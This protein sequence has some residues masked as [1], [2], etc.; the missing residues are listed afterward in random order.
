MKHQGN[1]LTAIQHLFR[2]HFYEVSIGNLDASTV[3]RLQFLLIH[4]WSQAPK[5]S[6]DTQKRCATAG[7]QK[8]KKAT[9]SGPREAA[10]SQQVPRMLV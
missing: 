4:A 3:E 6:P 5:L 2:A 8:T 9:A 10:A 1:S 7:L